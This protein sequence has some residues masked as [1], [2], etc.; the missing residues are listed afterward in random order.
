MCTGV[1]TFHLPSL[2]FPPLDFL[3]RTRLDVHTAFDPFDIRLPGLDL[4]LVPPYVVLCVVPP[5]VVLCVV[6]QFIVLCVSLPYV[7]LCVV[8]PYAAHPAVPPFDV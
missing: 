7:A 6:L 2:E 1:P 5:C 3:E 4:V 8:L